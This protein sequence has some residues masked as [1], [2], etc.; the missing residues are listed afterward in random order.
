MRGDVVSVF[1][2]SRIVRNVDEILKALNNGLINKAF[3]EDII[4]AWKGDLSESNNQ[5]SDDVILND[6]FTI[7][8]IE[9]RVE[10]IVS[11]D[12]IYDVVDSAYVYGGR[13]KFMNSI[14]SYMPSISTKYSNDP[15][16]MLRNLNLIVSERKREILYE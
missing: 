6:I 13:P 2:I 15:E 9:K 4:E 11:I 1:D 7:V 8:Y 10:S 16:I 12:E 5:I 3:A 14:V